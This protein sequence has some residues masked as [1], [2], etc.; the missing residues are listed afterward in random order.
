YSTGPNP[1]LS[2]CDYV[3]DLEARRQCVYERLSKEL[4]LLVEEGV[5]LFFSQWLYEEHMTFDKFRVNIDY[6]FD[7]NFEGYV[8]LFPIV[9]P[10]F[11]QTEVRVSW[12]IWEYLFFEVY[13][14]AFEKRVGTSG[15]IASGVDQ[16]WFEHN[17][18]IPSCEDGLGG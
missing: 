12:P 7:V 5:D 8:P 18:C 3:L 13:H 11:G 4:D 6:A 17:A 10:I 1:V 14:G 15:T 2:W 9:V 16:C